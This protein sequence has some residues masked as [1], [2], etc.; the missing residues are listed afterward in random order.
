MSERSANFDL[1]RLFASFMVLWSH[2]FVLNGVSEPTLPWIGTWSY[3][4]VMIF[5]AISGYLNAQ[6]LFRSRSVVTFLLS[7]A[8]RIFPALIVCMVFCVAIGAILTTL[9]IGRYFFPDGAGLFARNAPISF[10]QH[11][12]SLLFGL[13]YRLPGVFET[14]I[15][16]NV[17]NGSLWTL[18]HELKLYI[19]S[20]LRDFVAASSPGFAPPAF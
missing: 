2:H 1:I 9:D 11:N 4:G 10:I 3:L 19:F 14:N 20:P 7:R 16:P 15:Y 8:F 17:V 5:F 18:P 6:S 13:D 12:S